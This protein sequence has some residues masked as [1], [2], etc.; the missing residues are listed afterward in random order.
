[1]NVLLALIAATVPPAA[2]AQLA[3]VAAAGAPYRDVAV[4][5]ARGWKQFGG[6]DTPLMGEHWVQ[7][8]GPDYVAGERLDFAR[9]SNL[10]YTTIGGKRVLTGVAFTVRIGADEPVPAG[11]AGNADK[12]HVHD[13]EAAVRAATVDR[14][15]L[16][17]LANW[18][19]DTNYRSKGDKR[20]RIAMVHAWVTLPNPDGV[21]ADYNRTLP[22]LKL[23]LPAT[24]ADGAS[25]AA[26]RGLD[27]A[28]PGG[29][30]NAID[31]GLWIA[32]A[33]SATTKELHR[34]CEGAAA[35]VRASLASRD[36]AKVNAAGS[37]GWAMFEGA[38]QRLLNPAQQARI[39]AITEHGSHDAAASHDHH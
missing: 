5:R 23:G 30:R 22:Y 29:C 27:L 1:M 38:R 34:A 21:F 28:T 11:F 26:A 3:T 35:H 19:L 7:K 15:I 4:A 8:D 10:M 18:W 36:A 12:W 37:H 31:G 6:E 20:A 32:N 24:W 17:W 39:A 14:P 13:F 2:E 16:G 9:P 25:M 33:S